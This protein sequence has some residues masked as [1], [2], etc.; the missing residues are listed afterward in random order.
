MKQIHFKESNK[1]LL[2]PKG[3]TDKECGSLPIYTDGKTCV[4]CWKIPF[5]KRV[6]LLFHGNIWLGVMSGQTQ[7]PVWMQSYKTHFIK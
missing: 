4:S 3:M 6:K 2:K 1:D 7:P 5:W